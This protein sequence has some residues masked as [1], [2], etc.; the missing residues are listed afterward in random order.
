MDRELVEGLVK[1]VEGLDGGFLGSEFD[2]E[3]AAFLG[4]FGEIPF[5][6][7]GARGGAPGSIAKVDDACGVDLASFNGIGPLEGVVVIF[8]GGLQAIFFK[9]GNPEG[10]DFPGDEA[11]IGVIGGVG[12]FMVNGKAEGGGGAG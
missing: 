8:K 6:V 12:G 5:V 3:D 11:S 9:E 7:C 1:E 2:Q 4:P 10:A